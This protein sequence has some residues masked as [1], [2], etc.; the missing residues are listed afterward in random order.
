MQPS[1]E[2]RDRQQRPSGQSHNDQQMRQIRALLKEF[3]TDKDE[4]ESDMV[5]RAL[6]SEYERGRREAAE[7]LFQ[8]ISGGLGLMNH[9]PTQ[10]AVL[11]WWNAV[12]P[13]LERALV[14]PKV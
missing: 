7:R 14:G 13:E 5:R 6:Q 12:R 4:S 8:L 10:Q 1:E 9:G 11:L 3:W 2:T